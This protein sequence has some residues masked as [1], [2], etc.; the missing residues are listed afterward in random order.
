MQHGGPPQYQVGAFGLQGDGLIEDLQGVR[1]DVLVLTVLVCGHAQR[2]QL[3]QDDVGET[4]V[5][6]YLQ[7]APRCLAAAAAW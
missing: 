2:R 4:G 3:G 5:D 6:E 7:A 1:V